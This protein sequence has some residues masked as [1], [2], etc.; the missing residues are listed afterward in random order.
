MPNF[1]I[2]G[3]I[4]FEHRICKLTINTLTS[5][6]FLSKLHLVNVENIFFVFASCLFFNNTYLTYCSRI[7]YENHELL[8][9]KN[10][11]ALD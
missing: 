9:S 10:E 6:V 4:L 3:E 5:K 7:Y 8:S 2:I 1:K 11:N